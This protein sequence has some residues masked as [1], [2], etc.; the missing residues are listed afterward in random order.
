MPALINR[1]DNAIS[2]IGCE[3]NCTDAGTECDMYN[4]DDN[5]KICNIKKLK[6]TDGI[7]SYWK[8]PIIVDEISAITTDEAETDITLF[9]ILTIILIFIVLFIFLI[10]YFYNRMKKI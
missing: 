5:H 2:I 1:K 8:Y 7:D 4:Y 9:G 3:K 10:I 6:L